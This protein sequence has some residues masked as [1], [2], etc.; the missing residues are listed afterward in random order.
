MDSRP[1]VFKFGGVAVG[2]AD[3]IRRAVAHVRAAAP[4][5]AVVVSAMN[6]VTD[7]LLDAGQAALR[8]DRERC[9][10]AVA[11]FESRHFDL[12]GE[13]IAAPAAAERLRRLIAASAQEMTS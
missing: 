13:L 7:L 3:A 2:S 1:Q 4:N 11:A 6:G 12:I 10:A 5:V 8:G 9:A